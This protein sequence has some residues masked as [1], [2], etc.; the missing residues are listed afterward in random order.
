MKRSLFAFIAIIFCA[1]LSVQAGSE[2]DEVAKKAITQAALDYMDGAHDGDA[3][4]MERAVHP[5]LTKVTVKR[6]PNG[7][8]VIYKAGATRLIEI[9]RA[10]G[11]PLPETERD[12][13]VDIFAVR[14]GIAAAKVTSSM[15]Y[16]YL[17]LAEIEGQWKIVNILWKPNPEWLKKTQ[18][19]ALEEKEPADE[20]A[21]RKGIEAAALNYLEGYFT[22]DAGRMANG[23]H[24]ELTKVW[25]RTHQQTGRPFLDKIGAGFLI[26]A[27]GMGSGKLE[28]DKRDIRISIL[29]YDG[30]IALVEALS[31]VFFDYLQVARV[32]GEWRIINVLWT[33]NPDA[34]KK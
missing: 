1:G 19:E 27:A 20:G 29:D 26:E 30:D 14:E 3:T 17:L 21:D 34:P 8:D 4:R 22:G 16:D 12:I 7:K 18:P 11:A 31:A 5:E 28:E 32:N 24:P 2:V 33:L 15:F 13:T 6:M 25:P 10:N 9:I 23:V